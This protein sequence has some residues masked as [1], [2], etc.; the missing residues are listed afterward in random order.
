MSNSTYAPFSMMGK[1]AKEK[2]DEEI[3]RAFDE[4]KEI[5]EAPH[6]AKENLMKTN[7]KTASLTLGFIGR[8]LSSESGMAQAMAVL[9]ERQVKSAE[10]KE[11]IETNLPQITIAKKLPEHKK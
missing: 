2:I 4:L 11:F 5:R 10:F 3:N 1:E 9:G 8:L 6:A 7:F